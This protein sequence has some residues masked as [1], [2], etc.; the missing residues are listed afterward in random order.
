MR[1][2]YEARRKQTAERREAARDAKRIRGE[3]DVGRLEGERSGSSTESCKSQCDLFLIRNWRGELVKIGVALRH[4]TPLTRDGAKEFGKSRSGTGG[5]LN[6]IDQNGGPPA[7]K[8]PS[9]TLPDS[10][11]TPDMAS[12]RHAQRCM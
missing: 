7:R 12:W 2:A 5:R 10:G 1:V 8:I 3:T 11:P 9:A 4:G 6:H